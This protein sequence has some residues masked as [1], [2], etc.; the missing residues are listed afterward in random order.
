MGKVVQKLA[1]IS[2]VL[3]SIG[4]IYFAV[5]F[6][7]DI[8]GDIRPA[9]LW[10]LLV[11]FEFLVICSN[12][13]LYAFGDFLDDVSII[14]RKIELFAEK[15]GVNKLDKALKEKEEE[16]LYKNNPELA[17]AE[18]IAKKSEKLHWYE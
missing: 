3:G 2:M 16:D 5:F 14:R 4:A 7:R 17:K 8:Y 18:E 13:I 12:L 15:E 6:S 9:V 11:C 1:V 10:I